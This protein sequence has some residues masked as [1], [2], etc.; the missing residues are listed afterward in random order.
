MSAKNRFRL[1]NLKP[2]L[3]QISRSFW[4]QADARLFP[5]QALERRVRGKRVLITG[6]STGI[7]EVL[8]HQ[9]GKAGAR[10]VLVARSAEKLELLAGQIRHAGGLAVACP[11]DLSDLDDVDRLARKVLDEQGP[12]D[13]LINNAG[14]SIRRSALLEVDRFHDF[15]RTMQLNYFGA[16]RLTLAL[17]PAMKAHGGGHV[18][19]VSTLGI[20]TSP[21]RFS[22]YLASKGALESWTQSV[23]NEMGHHNV[24]FSLINLPLVR[25][26]M[27]AP[28]DIYRRAPAIS[29]EQAAGRICRAIVTRQKRVLSVFGVAAQGI[30]LLMP[31]VAEGIVNA[32]YQLTPESSAALGDAPEKKR[33]QVARLRP[34]RKR[35]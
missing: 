26:P 15:Q 29:P 5:D 18:I 7:G 8:A 16:I 34:I 14:R 10:L 30:Y 23:A 24:W 21:A 27:I 4:R 20:Q 2:H 11:A 32:G 3:H 6:A 35:S 19:N 9:L 13:I 1:P 33:A 22:A 28:T 31:R 25:T 12:V 17:L